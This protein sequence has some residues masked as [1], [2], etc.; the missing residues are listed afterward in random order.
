MLRTIINQLI[1]PNARPSAHALRVHSSR[2]YATAP[3]TSNTQRPIQLR[4]YQQECIASVLKSLKQGHKRVGISL[5]TGSG[6]TV[7]FTR[8]ID[9]VVSPSWDADRTLILAHRRELVEQAARHCQLAYPTKTI[10]IEM[11]NL[12]ATGTADITIASVRSLVSKDRLFKFDPSRFKLVL[13]DEAHHIVAPGYLKVLEHFGLDEKRKD[14]PS[15]IGV[16]ATFSRFDGV[17]LGAAIDEIVYHKDYVD[18]IS[19][20]WLCDVLFTTVESTANLKQVK[21]SS[22]GDFMTGELSKAVNTDEINDIIVRS[23]MAKARGRKSTLVFCVDIAHVVRLTEKF[24][25]HGFD[26]RYVT[27]ETKGVDRSDSLEAFKRGDFPVLVNC[28]VF[29]EG[30]DIPNIDCIVLARPTRSRNLLVQMIGRG[31]RLHPDK[32]DC[33]VI[34]LVSSLDTGIVTTPTLFGLD[35]NLLI[36]RASVKNM[37]QIRAEKDRGEETGTSSLSFRTIAGPGSVDAVTFT[38]YSSVLDLIADTSGEKH[39]RAISQYS[40]V[41][42]GQ[43]KFVLAAPGGTYIRIEKMGES[44]DHETPS[45]TYRV[46]EVRAIPPGLAKVPYAAP[47]EILTAATFTDAVHGADSFAATTYPHTFIHRYQRWRSLPPTQ[48]Q[49]DFINKLR[50][51]G[52]PLT[53]EELNKGKATDMITKLKHGARGQFAKIEAEQKRRERQMAIAESREKRERVT[54]GPLMG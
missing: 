47:K 30:T 25:Q 29:T 17:K 35:P 45:P 39:I 9:Q 41:Q 3:S 51:K 42:V 18:M 28:G 10:D 53:A 37:R 46:V 15:L 44:E 48:G 19:E 4:D 36:E 7:I 33:H 49:V 52:D 12:H 6:K 23:W 38:D 1:R 22:F 14:S 24:R 32:K 34:D 54:V 27:G 31:M 11:G 8:L 43:E 40:W 2:A 21:S 20:K 13:V 16:S 26:A 5:A 50:G